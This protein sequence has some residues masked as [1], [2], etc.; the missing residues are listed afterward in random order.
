[1]VPEFLVTDD[2]G[3]SVAKGK[4]GSKPIGIPAGAWHVSLLADPPRDL[5]TVKIDAGSLTRL[6]ITK[7]GEHFGYSSSPSK[8]GG[9]SGASTEPKVQEATVGPAQSQGL[10][11]SWRYPNGAGLDFDEKAYRLLNAAGDTVDEGQYSVDRDVITFSSTDGSVSG[12]RYTIASD[13]LSLFR[14][15]GKTEVLHRA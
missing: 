14:T 2:A 5:G 4:I 15:D 3:R 13:V 7:E 1:M 6:A 9:R 12:L 8:I 10:C 11:G